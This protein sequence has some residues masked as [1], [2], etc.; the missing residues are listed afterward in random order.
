VSKGEHHEP[1]KKVKTQG[2][3]IRVGGA[4]LC[5]DLV[6][7][8]NADVKKKSRYPQGGGKRKEKVN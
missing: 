6:K 7:R 1:K 2:D 5:S 3:L 4:Q 8:G